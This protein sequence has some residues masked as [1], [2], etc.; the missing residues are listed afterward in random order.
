MAWRDL[1]SFGFEHPQ[2]EETTKTRAAIGPTEVILWH[3]K[4]RG[5]S[6]LNCRPAASIPEDDGGARCSFPAESSA[7]GLDFHTLVT[8]S[9]W[10]KDL[11]RKHLFA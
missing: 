11:R 4:R 1:T 6:G 8:E 5:K 2:D 3:E 10:I 9:K 7:S